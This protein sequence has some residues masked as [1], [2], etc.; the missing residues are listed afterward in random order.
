LIALI[1]ITGFQM[2]VVGLVRCGW[3]IL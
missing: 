2:A 1:G 3:C